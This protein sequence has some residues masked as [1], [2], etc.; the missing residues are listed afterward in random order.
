MNLVYYYVLAIRWQRWMP[1]RPPLSP[2]DKPTSIKHRGQYK[3]INFYIN[4][5]NLCKSFNSG[6]GKHMW[7][8][9]CPLGSMDSMNPRCWRGKW[10]HHHGGGVCKV[11]VACCALSQ[12]V[13]H[14]SWFSY[15]VT[16][17]PTLACNTPVRC[18][19]CHALLRLY[20]NSSVSGWLVG[21][22]VGQST[23]RIPGLWE[24]SLQKEN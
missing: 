5:M 19:H 17:C 8:A 10:L 3:Y 6:L 20:F 7:K 12:L 15:N 16:I 13:S 9:A 18:W 11:P 23:I 24:V 22:L 2:A 21:R 4:L 14:Q 1:F